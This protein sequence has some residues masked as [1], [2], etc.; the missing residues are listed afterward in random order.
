MSERE[1]ASALHRL[2]LLRKIRVRAV[3]LSV[4]LHPGRPCWSTFLPIRTAP[5]GKRP[6]SWTS[7]R[8]PPPPA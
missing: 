6:R 2:E 3:M 5:S 8:L 7:P 1:I 4:G